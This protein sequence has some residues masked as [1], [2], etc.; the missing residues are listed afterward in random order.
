MSLSN[1]YWPG[2]GPADKKT[3]TH[4]LVGENK[5]FPE[6]WPKGSTKAFVASVLRVSL[7]VF[8]VITAF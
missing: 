3:T 7:V 4:D 2:S 5:A 6:R 8:S 1:E